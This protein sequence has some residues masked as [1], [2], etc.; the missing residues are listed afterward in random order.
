[1]YVDYLI[2]QGKTEET[3]KGYGY[4]TRIMLQYFKSKGKKIG[5]ATIQD[6]YQF[7]AYLKLERG[8][9]TITIGRYI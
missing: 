6:L 9:T 7:L 4:D 1:M 5:K 3:I 2:I 8:I